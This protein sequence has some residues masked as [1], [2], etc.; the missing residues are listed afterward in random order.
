MQSSDLQSAVSPLKSPVLKIRFHQ[1]DQRRKM[2]KPSRFRP[3]SRNFRIFQKF[4]EI[5]KNDRKWLLLCFFLPSFDTND[6]AKRRKSPFFHSASLDGCSFGLLVKQPLGNR[7]GVFA[8][9]P[10]P[11]YYFGLRTLSLE[12]RNLSYIPGYPR[13]HPHRIFT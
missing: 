1:V 7:S 4:I 13:H 10:I 3:F 9:N 12:V 5:P 11:S 2:N 6:R 8:S